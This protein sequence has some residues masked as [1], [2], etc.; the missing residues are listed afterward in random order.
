MWRRGAVCSHIRTVAN[1]LR[2]G[3]TAPALRAFFPNVE[4][5]AQS[6]FLKRTGFSP[7]F[8]R[9]QRLPGIRRSWLFTWKLQEVPRMPQLARFGERALLDQ[10][11]QVAG[12]GRA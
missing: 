4:L 6:R 5:A 3:D 10:V 2:R 11:L 7:F 8:H 1:V 12:R 9:Y